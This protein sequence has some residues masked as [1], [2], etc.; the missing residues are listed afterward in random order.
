LQSGGTLNPLGGY[1]ALLPG[2]VFNLTST[3]KV[4]GDTP[5][6]LPL[7]EQATRWELSD[8]RPYGRH[9]IPS[10]F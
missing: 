4:Y 7:I 9:G 10:A 1:A 5:N 6:R 8:D 3:N 2:C